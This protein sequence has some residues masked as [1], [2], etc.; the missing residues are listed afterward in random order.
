MLAYH[1]SQS[2]EIFLL[3]RSFLQMMVLFM[4]PYF[5]Q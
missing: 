4:E 5:L 1:L 2:F 3:Q